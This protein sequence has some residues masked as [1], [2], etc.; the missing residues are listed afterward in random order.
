MDFPAHHLAKAIELLLRNYSLDEL[1][2]P[3]LDCSRCI[4]TQ[5]PRGRDF[6]LSPA[7][8]PTST[9]L[10]ATQWV[11][12]FISYFCVT[13]TN[14]AFKQQVPGIPQFW[15]SGVTQGLPGPPTSI[16]QATMKVSAS[17]EVSIGKGSVF[18]GQSSVPSRL[19]QLHGAALHS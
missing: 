6:V 5:A 15:G 8:F 2:L 17:A 13:T 12:V 9:M 1:K 14:S 10:S 4:P 11:L 18:G 3:T 16:S 7:P 19:P